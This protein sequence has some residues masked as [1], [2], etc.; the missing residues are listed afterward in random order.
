MKAP[1]TKHQAPTEERRE[2]AT[3]IDLRQREL[4]GPMIGDDSAGLRLTTAQ[5]FERKELA[6]VLLEAVFAKLARLGVSV[7]RAT[8]RGAEVVN[9]ESFLY[10]HCDAD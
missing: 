9:P 7:K 3:L 10:H 2:L 1:S 4:Y 8:G 5:A 6:K